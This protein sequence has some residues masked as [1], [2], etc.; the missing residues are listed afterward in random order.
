MASS[1]RKALSLSERMDVI[2]RLE[3]DESQAS[4]AK[5]YGVHPSAI[6]RILKQKDQ[7]IDAWQNDNLERKRNRT[8]KVED[9]E[10]ALLRWFSQA[11][12]RQLPVSGPLLMEK[13]N[14]LA[15]GLG[16]T[17]FRAT[18]GWLE[19]WKERNNIK[20][21]KQHGEKQEKAQMRIYYIYSTIS[22]YHEQMAA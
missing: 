1:K 17:E 6:S 3:E 14:M 11:R 18:V 20:F 13:V 8:G 10:E 16:L 9:V 22:F 12:S 19:C 5:N 7:I 15:E 4:V 2:K 21:K